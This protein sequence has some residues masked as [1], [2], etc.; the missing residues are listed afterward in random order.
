MKLSFLIS[1]VENKWRFL[2]EEM[3]KLVNWYTWPLQQ[4]K[5]VCSRKS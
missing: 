4:L 1:F 2:F 3:K 5:N